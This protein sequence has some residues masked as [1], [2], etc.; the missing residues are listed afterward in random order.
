MICVTT[1][2]R[3]E[4]K[5][6]STRDRKI[7]IAQDLILAIYLFYGGFRFKATVKTFFFQRYLE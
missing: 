7:T 5:Y 6:S 2:V 3:I 1:Y 4:I